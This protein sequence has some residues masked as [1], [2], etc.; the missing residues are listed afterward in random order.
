[1][2]STNLITNP[3]YSWFPG[4]IFHS[5]V[6]SSKEST[7]EAREYKSQSI[8][9]D[10]SAETSLLIIVLLSILLLGWICTRR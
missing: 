8:N 2:D 7:I 3:A 5:S 10:R 4:N 9:T 6:D 1:M